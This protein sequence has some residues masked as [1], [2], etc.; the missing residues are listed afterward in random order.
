[1]NPGQRGRARFGSTSPRGSRRV[2]KT[3]P[4]PRAGAVRGSRSGEPLVAG[5]W[6]IARH[7][8]QSRCRTPAV[9]PREATRGC[10]SGQALRQPE[11]CR[12]PARSAPGLLVYGCF[13]RMPSVRVASPLQYFINLS[14][15][16]MKNHQVFLEHWV[17]KA[18]R[19]TRNAIESGGPCRSMKREV[20]CES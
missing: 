7:W 19:A 20:E 9:R 1:M 18:A 6:W 16:E 2:D 3:C 10:A 12:P 5:K 17:R 8:F 13:L 11:A 15:I 4:G 14:S